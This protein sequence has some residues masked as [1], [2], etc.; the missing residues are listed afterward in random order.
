MLTKTDLLSTDLPNA[1]ARDV[2]YRATNPAQQAP[3]VPAGADPSLGWMQGVMAAK[4]LQFKQNEDANRKGMLDIAQHGDI[5]EERVSMHGAE[6]FDWKRQDRAQ[7]QFIQQGMATS[8]QQGGYEGV[9]DFLGANDPQRAM[10]FTK[11]KLELDASIMGN[12]VMQSLVPSKQ[13]E[14]MV[15]GYNVIGKMGQSL[16]NAPEQDRSGMYQHMLP[17]IKTI[18]PNASD[19]LDSNAINM[20]M[21]AAGQAM[22]ESQLFGAQ[23]AQLTSESAMGKLDIDIRSRLQNGETMENSPSLRG[24]ISEYK[25]HE[26]NADYNKEKLDSIQYKN[27]MVN[28][29]QAKDQAQANAAKYQITSN[30]NSKL[31]AESKRFIE[32]QDQKNTFEGAMDAIASGGGGAAQTAAYRNVAMMFNKGALS[33]PDVA[34]FANSDNTV[35]VA[36]KK[37]ESVYSPN[38]IQ[39]LN[40]TE[41]QRLRILVDK[42]Y[43]K[44]SIKQQTIN[45]RYKGMAQKFGV[46][47]KDLSIYD[48]SS[49]NDWMQPNVPPDIAEQARAA[50]AAGASKAAVNQRVKELLKGNQ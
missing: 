32:L 30:M 27:M 10:D 18:N 15:E 2:Q 47:E 3:I 48:P 21:L 22:P 6:S 9:I 44:A 7:E 11:Q 17:I 24:M 50:V 26:V 12:K 14:A 25:Q 43:E 23:R 35:A 4:D 45:D 37:L 42:V 40:P 46:D 20:F 8:F 1:D 33:E 39:A 28:A 38:G 16:L 29:G 5:R 41:I 19:G 36:R 31:Q 13:A 34:A 49:P